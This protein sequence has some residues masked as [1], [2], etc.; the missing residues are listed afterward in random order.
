M[1]AAIRDLC[2]FGLG[3]VRRPRDSSVR[4]Q[5]R[6]ACL[7]GNAVLKSVEAGEAVD[8]FAPQDPRP[9]PPPPDPDD[10]MPAPETGARVYRSPY[11]ED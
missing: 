8:A 5:L 4:D 3:A 10:A 6:R 1:A 7:H 11:K 9:A 2:M